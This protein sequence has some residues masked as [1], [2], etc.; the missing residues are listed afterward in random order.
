MQTLLIICEECIRLSGCS[1][2]SLAEDKQVHV[3]TSQKVPSEYK[4]SV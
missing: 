3:Q 4:N 2:V 1:E